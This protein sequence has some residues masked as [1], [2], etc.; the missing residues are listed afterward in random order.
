MLNS[1]RKYSIIKRRE[2]L[3]FLQKNMKI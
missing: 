2:K 3:N 1:K